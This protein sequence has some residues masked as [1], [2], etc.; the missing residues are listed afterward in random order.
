MYFSWIL[1]SNSSNS[2]KNLFSRGNKIKNNLCQNSRNFQSFSDRDHISISLLL[3]LW[4]CENPPSVLS[5]QDCYFF[6]L[7]TEHNLSYF[8]KQ[9]IQI[10]KN[11]WIDFVTS[12]FIQ[13][14]PRLI[15]VAGFMI[16][17]LSGIEI[18]TRKRSHQI[19]TY[20]TPLYGKLRT[21][22]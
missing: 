5:Q 2:Y 7:Q 9:T 17:H 19:F 12:S 20:L 18:P 4:K 21:I 14:S 15:F 1:Y 6:L 3:F 10:F 11:N 8:Y 13:S 16:R 22:I